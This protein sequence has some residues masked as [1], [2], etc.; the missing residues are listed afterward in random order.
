MKT[1]NKTYLPDEVNYNGQIFYKNAAI[2]G[3]MNANNTSLN[4]IAATLKKEGLKA[5]CV[6]V[7]HRNLKG[8]TDLHGRPYQPTAHIFT[9]K[10][11]QND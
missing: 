2:S 1:F 4:T 9:N 3:A 7:L 5:V 10:N 11:P 6:K 8:R